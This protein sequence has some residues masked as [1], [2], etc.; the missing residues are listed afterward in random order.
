MMDENSNSKYS[1]LTLFTICLK[2]WVIAFS[3]ITTSNKRVLMSSLI[4][5]VEVLDPEQSG[6][7]HG[8]TKSLH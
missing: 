3:Y 1:T 5:N 2:D 7:F 8:Y 4:R 6:A